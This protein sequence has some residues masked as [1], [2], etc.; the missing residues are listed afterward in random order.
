MNP[1]RLAAALWLTGALTAVPAHAG[2]R[3]WPEI[4]RA[5][6]GLDS[7]R[8][9]T[10][11]SVLLQRD[12]ASLL[13]EDGRIAFARP[14]DGHTVALVYSGRGTLAFT[15]P[16][17]IERE[18][19]R[20]FMGV[21]A[22]RRKFRSLVIVATDSTFEELLPGLSFQPDTLRS[23]ARAW[24]EA[25]PYLD[26]NEGVR[27]AIVDRE[28]GLFWAAVWEPKQDPLFVVTDPFAVERVQLWRTAE[29]S[30]LGLWNR[31]VHETVCQFRAQGDDDTTSF[32]LR[33]PY[34]AEHY[35]VNVSL[36]SDLKLDAS[37]E[38]TLRAAGRPRAWFTFDI[39][40]TLTLDSVSAGGAPQ[41]FDGDPETGRVWVLADPPVPAGET[42]TFRFRYHG[43]QFE[44]A[45]DRI[46]TPDSFGWYPMVWYGGDATWDLSFHY[47]RSYQLLAPGRRVATTFAGDRVS[48]RWLVERPVSVVSFDV[49]FLRGLEVDPGGGAPRLTVWERR[50]DGAGHVRTASMTELAD[51]KGHVERVA[52]DLARAARFYTDAF[53]SAVTDSVHAVE[54]SR[55]R[56]PLG[57]SQVAYQAF[58]GLVRMMTPEDK[59]GT[60][61]EWTPDFVRAHELAHQWWGNGVRPASYHDAWLSEGFAN[62]SALWYLQAGRKDADT[63][64]ATLGK[65][66]DK[67][68]QNRHFLLG[69]GQEAGPIWLGGRTNSSSTENDYNL[70]VYRKGAWVLH[71]LRNLLLDLDSGDETRFRA[72]LHDFHEAH[73]AGYA[74]TA[75]F[76]A[77]AEGAAGEDLGWFFAQWVYG[78]DVPTY[79]WSWSSSEAP[80]G[81]WVVHGHVAQSNVPEG[82]RAPVIVRLDFGRGRFARTRVWVSGSETTFELP[83]TTERPIG[84][85]FNDLESV[86]AEVVTTK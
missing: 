19:L 64:L 83:A 31:H 59:V 41:S 25:L 52:F 70:I 35:S 72:L 37:A 26:R 42:R 32:D 56:D 39:A 77:A 67:L 43:E 78:T 47:P 65:W 81:H 60:G 24:R 1:F 40:R 74:T 46:Y 16:T 49:S 23:L 58:P 3:A 5:G 62:F 45:D 27:Q 15:P 38:V 75:D 8:I 12:A 61:V 69:S 4:P 10:V 7:T 44:R 84:V 17:S 30:R 21:P 82:F 29:D 22:L 11:R 63:Y 14:L 85:R 34:R 2:G 13:L 18:Q 51:A 33:A 53:G 6:W 57:P 48:S 20:R 55:V 9:A 54:V 50:P 36:A 79:R 73:R 68:L 76:R 86:L 28:P 71:M 80:A 66:R